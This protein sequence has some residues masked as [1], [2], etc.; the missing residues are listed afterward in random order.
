MLCWKVWQAALCE[1]KWNSCTC[2]V[3]QAFRGQRGQASH[4]W[5]RPPPT[6]LSH[7]CP[8]H[9]CLALLAELL[10]ETG[11]SSLLAPGPT[12]LQ[13]QPRVRHTHVAKLCMGCCC[14][15]LVSQ[16]CLLPGPLTCNSS[17]VSGTHMLQS[18][19]WAAAA[20]SSLLAPGPADLQLAGMFQ[21][22]YQ[23]HSWCNAV[24]WGLLLSQACLPP[25]PLTCSSSARSGT[26]MLQSYALGVAQLL[27]FRAFCILSA[28]KPG[29]S[30]CRSP[31]LLAQSSPPGLKPSALQQQCRVR[32]TLVAKL[33]VGCYC[34][35]G[36]A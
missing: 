29:L 18:S 11:Q 31:V 10:P 16:A 36:L 23:A 19:A 20:Q 3:R 14:Q 21:V 34:S 33:C 27:A 24:H 35:V 9:V 8:T 1:L 4:L 2:W 5:S 17:P 13:Q 32:R 12:D 26:Q 6:G 28:C 22:L 7:L 15:K 30:H 25:S